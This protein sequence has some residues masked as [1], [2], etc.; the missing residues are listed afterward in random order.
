VKKDRAA[1]LLPDLAE[2]WDTPTPTTYIFSLRRGAR[3]H[4]GPELTAADVKATFD[5]I[6][7]PALKSPKQGSFAQIREITVIDPYTVRF[8][9]SEPFAPFLLN[10]TLGIV[11]REAADRLGTEF[12]SRPIGTGPFRLHRWE[13]DAR[14]ELRSHP[15]YFE[16][17]P[18]LE[19]VVYKIIPDPTVRVLE[20]EKGTI[21]FLQNDIP[22]DLLPRLE[23]NP[24]LKVLKEPGT[25]Y[26]YVGFN[27]RDPILQNR[28]VRRALAHAINRQD[29]IAHVLRGLATPAEGILPPTHW[30]FAADVPAHAYDPERAGAL[31]DAAD[32][33]SPGGG[34]PR[35]RVSLKISQNE[36]QKRLAEALQAQLKAVGVAVTLQSF[37]WGTFF[38]HITSGNF[39]LYTLTWVGVTDPDIFYYI[40]HQESLPP[41]GANRGHYINTHLSTLI[42]RGRST[43]DLAGRTALYR[44]IQH[45]VAEDLPY[46][47]L[48]FSTNVAAMRADLQ[49]FEL[50]PAGDLTS[51]QRA[52]LDNKRGEASRHQGTEASSRRDQTTSSSMP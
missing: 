26:S 2:R 37:E 5:A 48:W 21:D 35:F 7:D 39:Q 42:E 3:F 46:I 28:A 13:A 1:Q 51:L 8:D 10:L 4:D 32:Y 50:Y 19:R 47:S 36:L 18:R 34:A 52:Y 38:A 16:G 23:R 49:G 43:L 25:N 12:A 27:L 31:L 6:R 41:K 17:P 15:D 20:L 45:T 40:F 44:M 11:P 30:A 24:R 9:L 22:P 29:L 14:L 33:P